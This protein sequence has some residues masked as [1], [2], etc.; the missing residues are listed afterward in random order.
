[1][2]KILYIA[3]TS[4]LFL[5][6]S[7]VDLNQEPL[8]FITEEEY[9]EYPKDVA[10]TAK[11]VT[12]LYND[13]WGGNYGFNSRLQR[14]N[15][16]ADDVTYAPT[17]ANN[18]LGTLA[19]L[20]PSISSNDADFSGP[21]IFFYKVITSANKIIEGTPIPTAKPEN[22]QK[23][24]GEAYFMRGL[25]YFYLV[26][27]FGDLP[28]MLTKEDVKEG[29]DR[30]TVAE[31]YDKAI[32]PSLT[33][34]AEW[35]PAK[36]RSGFSSTPSQWAAKACLADAYITMAGWPLNKGQEYYAKA[37]EVTK[38]IILN[39]G[40]SLTKDYTDLW[41]ELKKE[42]A[43][44]HMFALHHSAK[45]KTASNYG[46][47]YY[48]ADYFPAGWSD[49]YA[50]ESFYLKYP[51]DDRKAY[52]FMTEWPTSKDKVIQYKES[53]DGLPAI[54]KYYNYDEGAP[55]ASAQSNGITC[56]YRY[57]DVL[58]MYAEASAKATNTIDALALK[59]L[60]EVQDRS[61]STLTKTTDPNA[62][63][64]AVFNE[65]GWEFFAEMKRWFDLVRLQKVADAK[66]SEWAGSTFKANSH[67][68]F[69]IPF[70]QINLTGWTNNAGY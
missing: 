32:I 24:L 3:L 58:L 17:K 49:Y 1:M 8:S 51:N 21:W 60:Q 5:T 55:A 23:V 26:R 35:L 25:S 69:P 70:Q 68:Y 48:P 31:I 63:V 61:H 11:G 62:F 18:P 13:L 4:S 20:T 29:V 52:N 50:N 28:L 47:S 65:R 45:Q 44:E 6:T 16:S 14:L 53:L 40:L 33:K 64:E 66:P 15:V 42:E 2:K 38:D 43:N 30:T 37:A 27:L 41:K 54:S 57:A 9:I 34:A 10:S 36:S 19:S 46:K 59:S 39:S 12:A 56:I 7:C 67:Y 22:M